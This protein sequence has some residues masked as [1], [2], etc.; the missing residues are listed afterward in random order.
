MPICEADPW[1]LQYFETVACPADVRIPTEDSDAWEW[2]PDHRWVYDKLAVA[3]SQGLDAAPHGVLPPAYP[4]FSKPIY[5]LKGMGV[6]SCVL[7]SPDAY[8]RAYAPGHFWMTL[9]EGRHVSTDAV[10]VD[11]QV[12]WWRHTTGAP[13]GDGTFDHWT[14]HADADSAIEAWCGAWAAR[15]LR[16]Y[17]GMVN[18]ETIG[19]RIIEVHLRF[20][21]QWPDLYGRGWVEAV[22]KLYADGDWRFADADRRDGFSVVLFGPHGR[23]YRHPPPELVAELRALPG[24]CSVQTTFHEDLPPEQ[25]AMPPGGFRLAI[26][27]CTDL[28]AGRAARDRLRH[29]HVSTE[30]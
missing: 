2:F 22:V 11:G 4:V 5:N 28:D 21:D 12:R 8:M 16:G 24:I 23:R 9:L 27:N 10:V 17:A 26:I 18:F 30:V 25:H 14:V 29:N 1:R 13:A 20:A 6:G 19:G 3:R 15:H 7:D